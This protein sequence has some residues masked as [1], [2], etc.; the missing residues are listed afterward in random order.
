MKISIYSQNWLFRE[1]VEKFFKNDTNFEVIDATSDETKLLELVI[2]HEPD[3][4]LL[5]I[6]YY[7]DP[8]YSIIKNISTSFANVSIIIFS[9][10]I[11]DEVLLKVISNGA[12]GFLP[13]KIR[14]QKLIASLEGLRRGEAILTREMVMTIISDYS[15]L[16]R[17]YRYKEEK[18]IAQLTNREFEVLKYLEHRASNREIAKKLF[19]SE[20]TVRVHVHNILKKINV[21]NRREAASYAD[22]YAILQR[23][24]I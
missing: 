17:N 3:V 10:D 19:I 13:K 16:A 14:K 21:Q 2:R 9:S 15:R 4:I 12:K 22:R 5:D 1:G 20:N 8:E 6:D 24:D 23:K 7:E 18:D 11:S